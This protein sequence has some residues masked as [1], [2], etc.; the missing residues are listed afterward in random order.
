MR[1][2]LPNRVVEDCVGDGT[3]AACGRSFYAPER[4]TGRS[5]D[6]YTSAVELGHCNTKWF[7]LHKPIVHNSPTTLAHILYQTNESSTKSAKR[8]SLKW[9]CSHCPSQHF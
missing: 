5:D 9:K 7:G 6:S 1:V 4:P 3:C 8:V 2:C